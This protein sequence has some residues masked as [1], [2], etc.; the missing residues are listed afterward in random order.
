[1]KY[2]EHNVLVNNLGELIS[3]MSEL[4]S[5]ITTNNITE[6][7][8]YLHI[9][10]DVFLDLNVDQ[11]NLYIQAIQSKL[12]KHGGKSILD[13]LTTI[14]SDNLILERLL[15]FLNLVLHIKL[16]S[17][18]KDEFSNELFKALQQEYFIV[19]SFEYE[20]REIFNYLLKKHINASNKMDGTY[21]EQLNLLRNS[22]NIKYIGMGNNP[23][24]EHM[25]DIPFHVYDEFTH[26]YLDIKI[27]ET[28]D[29]L[30][31]IKDDALENESIYAYAMSH[32]ILLRSLFIIL[33]DYFK[34]AEYEDYY[35]NKCP[36]KTTGRSIITSAFI[37]NYHDLKEYG[38]KK[39]NKD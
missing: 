34:L 36:L 22:L 6:L 14:Y 7:Q 38:L 26:Q 23:F 39:V 15:V 37:E 9:E 11:I 4:P 25:K 20:L 2:I 18:S 35:L 1:M 13:D 27:K 17:T 24:K 8:E 10:S 30:L 29:V 31:S 5:I 21:I 12:N 16:K 3:F 33:D 28:I 32:Q 19:N